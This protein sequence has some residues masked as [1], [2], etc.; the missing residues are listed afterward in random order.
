MFVNNAA[1][2]LDLARERQREIAH[3]TAGSRHLFPARR[4]RR[5]R[6]RRT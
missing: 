3:R 4:S 1:V 2:M 6:R 5:V